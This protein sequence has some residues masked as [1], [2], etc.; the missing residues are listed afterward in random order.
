VGGGPKIVKKGNERKRSKKTFE[1]SA[2]IKTF[3]S[4]VQKSDQ[5]NRDVPEKNSK[6]KRY[7]LITLSRFH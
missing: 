7:L 1:V 6:N 4:C 5:K 3:L 2:R